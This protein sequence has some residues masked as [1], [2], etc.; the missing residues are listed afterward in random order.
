MPVAVKALIQVQAGVISGEPIA[1]FTK[2]WQ[3]DASDYELDC[4]T[5]QDLPTIFSLRLAEAHD[6]A[7]GLSNPKHVN[8]VR[9]DWMW[10]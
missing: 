2:H 7:M 10:L 6:Y 9:I 1:A 3:Y 4:K 5:P 8:W